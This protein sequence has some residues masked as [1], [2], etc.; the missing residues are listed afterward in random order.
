MLVAG[1][2][3]YDVDNRDPCLSETDAK[4]IGLNSNSNQ[5]GIHEIGYQVARRPQQ[6]A[7]KPQQVARRP[8]LAS[9]MG[10]FRDI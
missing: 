9:I 5:G 4:E 6:V 8:Q 1:R 3:G 2:H 7:R 10:Q